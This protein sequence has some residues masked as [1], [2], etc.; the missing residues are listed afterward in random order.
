MATD[1]VGYIST[2]PGLEQSQRC[3]DRVHVN[4]LEGLFGRFGHT[5]MARQAQKINLL[6]IG[7]LAGYQT[8]PLTETKDNSSTI[9]FAA[10]GLRFQTQATPTDNDDTCVTGIRAVTMTADKYYGFAARIQ[11]SSAAN[12][13]VTLGIVTSGSTELFTANPTDGV[14]IIK[15]KNAATLTARVVENGNAAVD[16]TSFRTASSAGAAV[17]MADATDMEL[18]VI[19]KAGSTAAKASGWWNIDGYITPFSAAQL[20]ALHT[21]L[22]TTAPTLAAQIGFRVNSTTQRNALVQFAEAEGDR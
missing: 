19:F 14:F 13:G 22:N 4:E 2:H 20:T 12:Y 6:S 9:A 15:A 1:L 11:V 17:S 8:A 16:V 7:G 3:S 18:G 5:W 10:G 21:L